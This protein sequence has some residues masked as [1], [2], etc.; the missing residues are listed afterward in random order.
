[1]VWTEYPISEGQIIA[2]SDY[3]I[4]I[5]HSNDSSPFWIQIFWNALPLAILI[6]LSTAIQIWL[7]SKDIQKLRQE[8]DRISKEIEKKNQE[9]KAQKAEVCSIQEKHD[10]SIKDYE[11]RLLQ[12][13]R[14]FKDMRLYNLTNITQLRKEL[15]F[16]RDTIRKILYNNKT[17]LQ[18][19][20][21]VI[22]AVTSTLKT[23][24]QEKTM[25]R[26]WMN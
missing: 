21:K 24:E 20:D 10:E 22:E 23:Y 16:W 9:F 11:Q 12:L 25:I 7:G 17:G 14:E 4:R 2:E 19:T 6:F 5:N 15:S 1:M 18:S 8:C 26:T 3:K 13:K